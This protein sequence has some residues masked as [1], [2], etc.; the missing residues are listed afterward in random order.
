[1]TKTTEDGKVLETEYR[2]NKRVIELDELSHGELKKWDAIEVDYL[3]QQGA[4]KTI[5]G[6]DPRSPST[7]QPDDFEG[8]V[9]GRKPT[10][11]INPSTRKLFKM[12]GSKKDP[13]LL[14]RLD[15]HTEIRGIEFP[16]PVPVDG[17]VQEDVTATV[18]YKSS[19]NGNIKNVDVDVRNVEGSYGQNGTGAG[20]SLLI[21][22]TN[23][24]RKGTIEAESAWERRIY[25]RHQGTTRKLGRVL[26]V[27]FPEGHQFTV[28]LK[29]L[30]DEKSD[31]AGRK[32]QEYAQTII[33]QYDASP[34]DTEDFQVEV[35][36]DG[37]IEE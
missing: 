27:E 32:L 9:F 16:G 19:R 35:E 20:Q 2:E 1:M 37:E 5:R 15:S 22:G 3:S 14:V 33:K 28:K 8:I 29:G 13:T 10:Y 25:T 23:K 36:Y 31:M 34:G 7:L 24:Y 18:W 21:E 6:G 12:N 30:P 26:R 4:E 17:A 11:G